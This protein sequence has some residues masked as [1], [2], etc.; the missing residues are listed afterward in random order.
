VAVFPETPNVRE[1]TLAVAAEGRTR[2]VRKFFGFGDADRFEIEVGI[3]AAAPTSVRLKG[4]EGAPIAPIFDFEGRADLFDARRSARGASLAAFAD[5]GPDVDGI[6]RAPLKA[7]GG[8][9]PLRVFDEN[10]ELLLQSSLEPGTDASVAL[11]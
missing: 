6:F 9:L 4:V 11:P 8:T 10:G 1:A 3:D 5:D 2:L 7:F